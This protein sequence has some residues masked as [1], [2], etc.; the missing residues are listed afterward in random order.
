M[1]YSFLCPRIIGRAEIGYPNRIGH[2]D[3]IGGYAA[4]RTRDPGGVD[5][6]V[7][8]DAFWLGRRAYLCFI[9]M[10]AGLLLADIAIVVIE[11]AGGAGA[12]AAAVAHAMAIGARS[13]L[14]VMPRRSGLL[15]HDLDVLDA[16]VVAVTAEIG[17]GLVIQNLAAAFA[18]CGLQINDPRAV[19]VI[20]YA[21]A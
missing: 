16:V 9:G 12:A 14:A 4:V 15:S 3:L 5:V 20:S 19:L 1:R 17:R 2:F 8:S 10:A 21:L 11:N 6:P 7:A 13:P 18:L